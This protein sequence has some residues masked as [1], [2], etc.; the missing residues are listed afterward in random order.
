MATEQIPSGAKGGRSNQCTRRDG[1]LPTGALHFNSAC[2]GRVLVAAVA[3]GS[4]SWFVLVVLSPHLSP[5]LA[6]AVYAVGALICHQRPERSFHWDGAQ[7][8]VCARCTGIYSA[9]V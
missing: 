9:P 2:N 1:L 7:L 3:A 4:V 5:A 8:A 6:A